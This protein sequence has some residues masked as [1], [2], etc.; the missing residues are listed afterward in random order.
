MSPLPASGRPISEPRRSA[1]LIRAAPGSSASSLAR[2]ENLPRRPGRKADVSTFEALMSSPSRRGG[3]RPSSPCAASAPALLSRRSSSNT[4]F[5]PSPWAM[6]RACTSGSAP[7]RAVAASVAFHA[8]KRPVDGHAP[9]AGINGADAGH[10]EPHGVPGR[11]AL[12]PWSGHQ[13][14]ERAGELPPSRAG[15]RSA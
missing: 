11:R 13:I 15:E 7:A 6:A 10:L 4:T 12:G 8:P 5:T 1:I 14:V 2:A 3:S 9:A